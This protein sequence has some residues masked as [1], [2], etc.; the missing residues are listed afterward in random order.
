MG[1]ACIKHGETK[2]RGLSLYALSIYA[3]LFQYHEEHQYPIRGQMLKPVT[4][5]E[6]SPGLSGN[7][8]QMISVASKNSGPSLT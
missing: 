1:V 8:M 2:Y 5:D 7:V 6:P 4:R 3:V